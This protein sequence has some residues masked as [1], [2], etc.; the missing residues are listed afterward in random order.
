[1]FDD[2]FLVIET[3][4]SWLDGASY[5]NW[6]VG[7]ENSNIPPISNFS[8]AGIHYLLFYLLKLIGIEDAQA[9]MYLVRLIHAAWSIVTVYL[10]YKLTKIL[11]NKKTAGLVGLLLATFWF[12]PFFSVRNL[13]EF[14]CIPL[15]MAGYWFL[16][17]SS[18]DKRYLLW[19]LFSGLLFGLAFNVR[20]QTA[21]IT[22]GV[23]II[24]L[25]Q[26]KF[27]E[28]LS[29][30]AG[31]IIAII[32]LQGLVDWIIWKVPFAELKDYVT[33]NI[34]H[35]YDY[36]TSPW[37][38]YILVLL[39]VLLPPVSLAIFFGYFRTWRKIALIFFPILLF[40]VFHSYFPNKQERFILPAVPFM[41]MLGVI[42]WNQFLEDS[43][44]W[45]KHKSWLKGSWIF[46]WVINLFLLATFT[47][48]YSKKAR[49]ESM[50]YLSR[51]NNIPAIL[52]EDTNHANAST[53]P[54]Y[55]LEQWPEVYKVSKERKMED[56]IIGM[57]KSQII[58][59]FVLFYGDD[60][61]SS[62]I[63]NI[64]RAIPNLEP[65]TIIQ[66]GLPD[67]LLYWLNP[68]NANQTVII[69][70]NT[71]IFPRKTE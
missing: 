69:Y 36:I 30:S 27:R 15:L 35:R 63:E 17:K 26:R 66:P 41:I 6:M 44:F 43:T 20:Y 9:K 68:I 18:D 48:M 7:N 40:L 10:G 54:L 2:H 13:V 19:A 21:L 3:A 53:M 1:M 59:G 32:L 46:F 65:E 12:M 52:L 14:A 5:K 67:K 28:T 8:Y 31:V 47:T 45:R 50:T 4:Q 25:M 71:D 61:L 29:F 51:Y 56:F 49:V 37:Y 55:Y 62:R 58:P 70:R 64:K 57:K 23:G 42:G 38:S 60:A 16:F 11:S 22:A 33:Y 24:L 34:S 39:S